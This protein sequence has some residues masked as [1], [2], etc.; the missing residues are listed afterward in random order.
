MNKWKNPLMLIA[1][2]GISYLG[3]WMYLVALNLTILK[4][5]GSPATVA[6]LFIIRPIA[7]LLTN[8]WSGSVIDRAN[9]RNLLVFTNVVR[10]ILV[11]CIPF[12]QSLSLIY[13]LLL[14]INMF[15][16]LFRPAST[17]FITKLVPIEQRKQFN[18]ILGMA[19]SG[20]MVLGPAIAGVI[21]MYANTAL[22]IFF[23]ALSFIICAFL[24]YLLPDVDEE[25]EPVRDPFN[26]RTLFGDM[27]IVKN[28][29][30][31]VRYFFSI[32]LLFQGAM[33]IDFALDSQEL[34]YI[35]LHLQLSDPDYG[36]IVSLTGVGLIIG[37]FFATV[38][39]K[40]IPLNIYLGAGMLL[41]SNG[42][43]FFFSSFDFITATAAFVC[44]G[45]F[46]SFANAGYATFFQ[47]N[48]PVKIMGRIGSMAEIV[49]GLIQISLTLLLGFLAE[50]FSVQSVCLTFAVAGILLA[51]TL[52]FAVLPP[53]RA[54]YFREK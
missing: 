34:T 26:W 9:K 40:K 33:L 28:F 18:S 4:I 8:T 19:S 42:Y 32:Y 49:Q 30:L 38:L 6:G 21:I 39:A 54:N 24:I 16:A 48:V 5:T 3:N 43:F 51:I 31:N 46:I 22:C 41:T 29:L 52:F 15:G 47:N 50:Q 12:L 23:N 2:I 1:G 14:I 36:F 7:V 53:A 11:F 13:L 17:V 44:V 25:R 27:Q 37:A 45:F 10:G 35:K 20:A